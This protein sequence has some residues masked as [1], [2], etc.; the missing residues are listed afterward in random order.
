MPSWRCAQQRPDDTQ[1]LLSG[2]CSCCMAAADSGSASGPACAAGGR[3]IAGADPHAAGP[4]EHLDAYR[5]DAQATGNQLQ[6]YH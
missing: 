2:S 3:A 5:Q 1:P 4:R 6:V